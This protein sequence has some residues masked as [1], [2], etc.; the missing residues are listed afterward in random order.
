MA[1]QDIWDKLDKL[2]DRVTNIE[3]KLAK[4]ESRMAMIFAG[5]GVAIQVV[6]KYV[7]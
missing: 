6:F 2:T 4:I 3:V 7:L 1:E 5:V